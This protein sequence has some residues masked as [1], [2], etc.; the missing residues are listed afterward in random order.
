M[1]LRASDTT[2]SLLVRVPHILPQPKR[3]LGCGF[4][5]EDQQDTSLYHLQS[6]LWVCVSGVL[7]AW[8]TSCT[9]HHEQR[10]RVRKVRPQ[11]SLQII[12]H[13]V[14]V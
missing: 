5:H 6:D 1:Q 13:N 10:E 9:N 11:P 2:A 4:V 12:S 3:A 14:D 7:E 8:L